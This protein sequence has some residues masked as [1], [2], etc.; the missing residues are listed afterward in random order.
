MHTLESLKKKKKT[1]EDLHSVVKTMKA[2]AAVSIRQYER[3]T[4]SLSRYSGVIDRGFQM[5]LQMRAIPVLAS[6][7]PAEQVGAVVFGSDQGMCGQL[8][9]RVVDHTMD[10][11]RRMRVGPGNVLSLAVGERIA[12]RLEERGLSADARLPVPGSPAG[13]TPVVFDIIVALE[14][15]RFERGI[16]HVFLFFSEHLSGAAYQP[17]TFQLLPLD[18]ERLRQVQEEKWPTRVLPDIDMDWMRLFERLVRQY[19]FVSLFRACAESLASENASRLASMQVAERNIED[20]L[21]ELNHLY[22][23]QRQRSITEEL[24]DI[25]SGYT[26]LSAGSKRKRRRGGRK[27][28]NFGQSRRGDAR[29]ERNPAPPGRPA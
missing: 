7:R 17:R 13:I 24:L 23:Q 6:E 11:L 20:R 3:A 18:E 15:W 25:V 21:R 10:A 28:R 27:R 9:D 29:D 26:T 16:D 4:E 1:A 19:L 12:G 2:L 22:R 14:T 5:L 8:N